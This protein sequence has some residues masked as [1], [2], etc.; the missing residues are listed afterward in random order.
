[1]EAK[2]LETQLESWKDKVLR[3]YRHGSGANTYQMMLDI[4]KIIAEA[5]NTLRLLRRND[6]ENF[7]FE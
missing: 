2:I 6:T 5:F 3:S 4:D 1:M 7:C